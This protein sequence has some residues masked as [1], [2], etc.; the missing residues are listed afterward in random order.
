M[1]LF[2][3]ENTFEITDRGIVLTPGLGDKVNQVMNGSSIK[4]ILPDKSVL[5]SAISGINFEGEHAIFIVGVNKENVPIGTE[6]WL[7]Q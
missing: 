3:V 1:Y 2:T 4:L 5:Y 6:V 7:N